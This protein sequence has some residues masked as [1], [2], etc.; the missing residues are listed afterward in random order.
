MSPGGPARWRAAAGNALGALRDRNYRI[1]AGGNAVSLTGTWMQRIA[2]GWLAWQLTHS[3]TWLGLVAFA[4]LFPAVVL[5]PLSGSL[6]DR[7]DRRRILWVT[8]IVSMAQATA[9][10]VLT[11]TGWVTIES[12]FG[13]TVVLGI[14]T[15]LAQPARLALV[16]S[17]ADRSRLSSAVALNSLVF[18]LARFLGP[19][20]A[21]VVIAESGLALA[22]ALNALSYLAFLLAL[23]QLRLQRA[24]P[25]NGG[26]LIDDMVAGYAYAARHAG[27][28]PILL[29]LAVNAVALRAFTELLPGFADAVF[30]RGPQALAWLTAMIGL[31][32]IAGALWVAQRPRVHGLTAVANTSTLVAALAVLGFAA[33]DLFWFALPCLLVAGVALVL[34]GVGT[35]TLI[36]HAVDGA[37]RGR[38]L[39]LYGTLFRG[40]PAIGALIMGWLSNQV[41]L[42]WP[43]AGGAVLCVGLWWW[44]RR[45]ETAIARALEG[46]G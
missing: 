19:V 26:K 35:Q 43:V 38:V 7:H 11:V 3:G 5:S 14:V 23:M 32:A 13:L 40:G 2:V 1:Y 30:G 45:R 20:I 28:G 10:A 6:A 33:T 44:A 41:G 36:Q 24:P 16:P 22:F 27:I 9:L 15:A 12:L 46:E 18:N 21:G 4:D 42:R 17:L 25:A 34:N 39:S 8:Q 29:L 37:M 31:G